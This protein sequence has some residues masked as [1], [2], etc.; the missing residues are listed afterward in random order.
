M[1]HR[2]RVKSRKGKESMDWQRVKR[3]RSQA[4]IECVKNGLRSYWLRVGLSLS[5]LAILLT[6]CGGRGDGSPVIATI[7]GEE[8]HSGQMERFLTIKAGELNTDD[9]SDALRSQMLDEYILR[10]LVLTAATDA[11]LK[12]NDDEIGQAAE[13][14]PQIKSATADTNTRAELADD[15]LV[16]KYYRQVVLKGVK[17]TPEEI[18][19]Y[20]QENQPRLAEKSGYHVREIRVQSREEAERLRL[21]VT[22][23][24]KD[25]AT[26]A[27]QYS[28]APN[29]ESGGLSKYE[30][31]HLPEFLKRTLQTLRLGE[32][33]A[34]IQSNFGYHLFL[35][36]RRVQPRPDEERR[37]QMYEV[38]AQ[39]AEE[40]TARKNQQAIEEA[41]AKLAA[42]A[43]IEITSPSRLG[44]TY[45][46][47]F[48]QN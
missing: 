8:I 28:D 43:A 11:G 33:S 4:I 10:R 32:V 9:K 7:N 3:H 19:A 20:V 22:D 46:G 30:E 48:R 47:R 37:S 26:I 36:E 34:V 41:L 27:R 23:G 1:I 13:Q 31:A 21:E 14:N 5:A 40:L 24:H 18:Q 25:F 12:V 6:A 2:R 16:E 42:Q 38:T 17:V 45:S 44:F 39:L 15:L 29:A 35:L